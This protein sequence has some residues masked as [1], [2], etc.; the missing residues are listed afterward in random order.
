MGISYDTLPKCESGL[1]F[2]NALVKWTEDYEKRCMVPDL[3]NKKVAD[4]TTQLLLYD[5][6]KFAKPLG[7][8]A[9]SSLLTDRLRTAMMYP[10]PPASLM[11]VVQAAL[12]LRK[13]VLRWFALPRPWVLRK[14]KVMDEP[15]S[16][17]RLFAVE[18]VA[19]PW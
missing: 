10:N 7:T 4:E 11:A 6:P 17:G 14:K 15:D 1:E 12:K 8:L 16:E 3:N 19:E 18:Y 2:V 5:V 13:Y 9:V